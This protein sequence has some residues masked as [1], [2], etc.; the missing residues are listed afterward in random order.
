MAGATTCSALNGLSTWPLRYA[1]AVV[2]EERSISLCWTTS[3]IVASV[4]QMLI[5]QG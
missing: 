2:H 4:I 3:E 5:E 1:E